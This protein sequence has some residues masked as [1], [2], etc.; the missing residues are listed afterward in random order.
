MLRAAH[1]SLRTA[2]RFAGQQQ[3]FEQQQQGAALRS[4]STTPRAGGPQRATNGAR[5]PSPELADFLDAASVAL[6]HVPFLRERLMS[7]QVRSSQPCEV[8][9]KGEGKLQACSTQTLQGPE[10]FILGLS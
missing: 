2:F 10:W 5:T 6:W 9:A 3:Q 7:L 8:C 1:A 4:R